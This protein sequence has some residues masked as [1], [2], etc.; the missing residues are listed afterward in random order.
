MKIALLGATGS[1]GT[2]TL[3]AIRNCLPE[4]K[5]T[6]LSGFSNIIALAQLVDEFQPDVCWVPGENAAKILNENK[7][8][9]C[10]I[11]FGEKNLIACAAE[12]DAEIVINALIGRVGLAPTIAAIN[13]KKNIA[14]ANKEPLV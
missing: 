2:Q 3:D 8:F 14:L 13:A 6:A 5:I 4:A 12:T 9:N 11:L 10:E 7:K 1:I